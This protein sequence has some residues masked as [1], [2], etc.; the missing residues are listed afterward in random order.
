MVIS[1]FTVFH[2]MLFAPPS[3]NKMQYKFHQGGQG[4]ENLPETL[5]SKRKINAENVIESIE[6][7]SVLIL[8]YIKTKCIQKM[9]FKIHR[10]TRGE[11]MPDRWTQ[12]AKST[13]LINVRNVIRS[14]YIRFDI[15]L[16]QCVIFKK[17]NFLILK[18]STFP[19]ISGFLP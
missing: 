16:Y 19:C 1:N 12:S 13:N 15:D 9:Q 17:Q 7:I 14:N 6:I 5:N 18:M 2:P 4:G 10:R 3:R 8:T 11:N